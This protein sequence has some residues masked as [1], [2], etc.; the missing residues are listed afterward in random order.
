[1]KNFVQWSLILVFAV[2]AY[3]RVEATMFIPKTENQ[4]ILEAE[5]IC[6]VEVLDVRSER[7]QSTV[8]TKAKVHPIECPKGG[9]NRDFIVKWPGGTYKLHG[10][11]FKTTVPG[12]PELRKGQKVILY[13]WRSS[14]KD[15]WTVHNW[16]NGVIPLEEDKQTKAL[17]LPRAASMPLQP[18]KRDSKSKNLQGSK[19]QKSISKGM[20]L[21][22]YR[23]KVQDVLSK[24][25]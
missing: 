6:A 12:T 21:K 18:A 17:S 4:L 9:G 16:V 20:S 7:V 5:W 14:P 13:L 10:Q 1:M 23:E 15:D 19:T 8:V 3:S 22:S 24:N 11:V 2:A 25:R